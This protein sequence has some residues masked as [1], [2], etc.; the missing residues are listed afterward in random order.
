[1]K[2]KNQY[3][4]DGRAPIPKAEQTSRVM[5]A[6]RATETGPEVTLR[7]ALWQEGINGYRKNWRKA[8]GTPDIAFPAKKVAIFVN[9]CFWHRCKKCNLPLP[10]SNTKFWNE[11][12]NRNTKRD[13][14]KLKAIKS[15]GWRV[16]IVWEC[17]IKQNL[18]RIVRAIGKLV[19][20]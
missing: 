3:Q 20:R 4:R 17:D 1:M 12:F 14:L 2:N 15:L 10:K 19:D 11:K 9:G 13:E 6:N 18:P 8:P 16:L 5:S 7:K